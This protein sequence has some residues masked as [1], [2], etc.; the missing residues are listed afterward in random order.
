V[1]RIKSRTNLVVGSCATGSD[2]P[3]N[4]WLKAGYLERKDFPRHHHGTGHLR[5]GLSPALA[6]RTPDGL[7][8]LL[9]DR[10]G[11]TRVSGKNRVH[12]V[13]E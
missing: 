10:F 7:E 3:D 6:N 9:A 11:G 8:T 13:H 4:K 1:L 12:L 2:D 5:A